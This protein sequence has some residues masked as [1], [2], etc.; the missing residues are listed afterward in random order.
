MNTDMNRKMLTLLSGLTICSSLFAGPK[1]KKTA[2]AH[3][4][5]TLTL[6]DLPAGALVLPALPDNT[7][8]FVK[9]YHDRL[10]DRYFLKHG[11]IDPNASYKQIMGKC[12]ELA[13]KCGKGMS[14]FKKIY[15]E[16]FTIC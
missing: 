3:A 1:P 15:P 6:N 9:V 7:P 5:V 10:K 8:E 2:E 14:L 13:K 16:L 12:I 4:P 11:N